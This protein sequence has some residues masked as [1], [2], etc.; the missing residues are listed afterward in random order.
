MKLES[1]EDLVYFLNHSS[2]PMHMDI[3]RNFIRIDK[4]KIKHIKDL[5]NPLDYIVP[6]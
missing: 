2:L 3:T 6:V 5:K 4:M 1:I